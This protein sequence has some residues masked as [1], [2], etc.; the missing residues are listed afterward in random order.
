MSEN[1]IYGSIGSS[2]LAGL[3]AASTLADLGRSTPS[4]TT[5]PFRSAQGDYSYA[6][7]AD[8]FYPLKTEWQAKQQ[9]L[10][11]IIAKSLG[12]NSIFLPKKID[13]MTAVFSVFVV[14]QLPH[15]RPLPKIAPDVDGGLL[16]VWEG[17]RTVLATV[18]GDRIHIV[19][20]PGTPN[21]SH[22]DSVKLTGRALP[23]ELLRALESV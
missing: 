20:D 10:T 4:A 11:G 12:P 22:F 16:M 15:D 2:Q 13:T 19:V 1:P 5:V 14:R 23:P 21:A 3:L 7:S 8:L 6:R 9:I 17:R 18:E